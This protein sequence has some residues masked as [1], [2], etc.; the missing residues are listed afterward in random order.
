MTIIFFI[1]VLI[2][3]FIVPA[4]R[5]SLIISMVLFACLFVGYYFL[6]GRKKR[7]KKISCYLNLESASIIIKVWKDSSTVA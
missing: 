2:V 1:F 6:A 3:L 4:T 7:V 5:V